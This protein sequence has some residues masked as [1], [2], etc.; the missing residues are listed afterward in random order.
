MFLKP[1]N[2]LLAPIAA[3][4]PIA[5]L[6][7]ISIPGATCRPGA[8]FGTYTKSCFTADRTRICHHHPRYSAITLCNYT[9][10]HA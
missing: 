9:R 5:V 6:A 3:L 2:A 4:A 10:F 7:P 8:T 1:L